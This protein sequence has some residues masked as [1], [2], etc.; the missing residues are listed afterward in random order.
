V[1][2][3]LIAAAALAVEPPLQ[4]RN[5]VLIISD[6]LRWQE[7]FRGADDAMMTREN[8]V[9]NA[10]QLKRM[11]WRETPEARREALMPFIWSTIATHGQL[12]GNLDKG[13]DARC[14]NPMWFSYPGYNEI[15][16]GF[17]DPAIDSNKP[18]PNANTTVFEWLHAKPAFAGRAAAFGAWNVFPAI[19]NVDRCGFLVSDSIEPVNTGMITPELRLLNRLKAET[20]RRWP[21]GAFDSLEFHTAIEWFKANKPRITFL[22]LGET[23]EWGH[24][25]KYAEYLTAARRADGYIREFWDLCQSMP[26]YKGSTTFLIT[27]DHGRGNVDPDPKDWNNHG[28]KHPGSG[29]TWIGIL[30]PDTPALG[31]RTNCEPVLQSQI[32]A[33]MAALLGEDYNAAEPRAGKVIADAI[34][35]SASTPK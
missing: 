29:Q 23:D 30:G 25:G 10:Y 18:I 9:E 13:S 11:F 7:V 2:P 34:K 31:E 16:C 35:P 12:Y 14:E 24:E 33:T 17:V 22:A 32:A 6:G 26:E 27:C 21:A 3:I 5:V 1:I 19:F 20:P 8:G 28:A 15:L 4:T